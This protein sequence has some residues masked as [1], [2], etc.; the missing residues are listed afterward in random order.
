MQ[1]AA[2]CKQQ[3]LNSSSFSAWRKRLT[4]NALNA[5]ITQTLP[6][7]EKAQ[8]DWVNVTSEQ[9]QPSQS[10]DVELALPSGEFI[11]ACPFYFSLFF[12]CPYCF[13]IVLL[14]IAFSI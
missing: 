10:W 1:I 8:N 14:F 6:P 5:V 2:F 7:I 12:I 9:V 4:N 3:K 11:S 13:F